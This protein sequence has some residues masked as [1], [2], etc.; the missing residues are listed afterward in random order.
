MM[1]RQAEGIWRLVG[2]RG[3]AGR[4]GAYPGFSSQPTRGSLPALREDAARRAQPHGTHAQVIVAAPAQHGTVRPASGPIE[5]GELRKRVRP[6][7]LGHLDPLGHFC[8][9]E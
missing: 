5:A 9:S 8:V 1:V 3:S 2:A 7:L 4:A 6:Q